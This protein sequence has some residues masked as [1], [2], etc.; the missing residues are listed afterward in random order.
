MSERSQQLRRDTAGKEL[1][2]IRKDN[3]PMTTI[4]LV[5]YDELPQQVRAERQRLRDQRQSSICH[6]CVYANNGRD[7]EGITCGAAP[8]CDDGVFREM[9]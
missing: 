3:K 7:S 2:E 6:G 4:K 5:P 8:D 9:P 1:E